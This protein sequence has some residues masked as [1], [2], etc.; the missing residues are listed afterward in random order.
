MHFFFFIFCPH[1]TDLLPYIFY[2]IF[3]CIIFRVSLL[4][5]AEKKTSKQRERKTSKRKKKEKVRKKKKNPSQTQKKREYPDNLYI[6]ISDL[7][8]FKL[9]PKTDFFFVFPQNVF[10]FVFL[11]SNREN[12]KT[13]LKEKFRNSRF[14]FSV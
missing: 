2:F 10:F 12:N 8:S 7:L 1:S 5:P 13:K 3:F 11:S 6:I 9:N 14:F 4:I